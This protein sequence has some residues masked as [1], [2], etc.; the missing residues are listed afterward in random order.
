[1]S[2]LRVHLKDTFYIYIYMYIYIYKYEFCAKSEKYSG[3]LSLLL[4][5]I[6]NFSYNISWITPD[7]TILV[8]FPTIIMIGSIS[9]PTTAR[10]D[11][12]HGKK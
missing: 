11:H 10:P 3:Y 2:G 5:L 8:I 1:M 12:T 6:Y 7:L 9:R 4:T